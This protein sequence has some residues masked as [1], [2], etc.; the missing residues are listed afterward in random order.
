M[1]TYI[2]VITNEILSPIVDSQV[3]RPLASKAKKDR[4]VVVALVPVGLFLRPSLKAKM[5]ETA[6]RRKKLY[7]IETRYVLSG[8][9][10]LKLP[11]L[12]KFLLS[13][14]L[15]ALVGEASKAILL[16]R[17]A[18]A[19]CSVMLASRKLED[20]CKLIFDC[21]GDG[22]SELVGGLGAGWDFNLWEAPIVEVYEQALKEE[23]R[24]CG[25]D[26][27]I[28]VSHK[29]A[30]M[31]NE[32]HGVPFSKMRIEPCKVDLQHFSNI[33]RTW[34]REQLNV[35]DRKV[36]C[37]LGSLAWYQLPDQSIRVYKAFK[38]HHP[39]AVFLAITTD[40]NKMK[41]MLADAGFSE[42]DCMAIQVSSEDVPR[43][44]SAADVGLLLREAN[45]VN[46]VASPVKFAE[47]LACGVP[48][49]L[50]ESIGDYSELVLT[51]GLGGVVDISR[52][53][54]H[55]DAGIDALIRQ[56]CDNKNLRMRCRLYVEENLSWS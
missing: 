22:P 3:F 56:L 19:M 15:C 17:N 48:V 5:Q 55:L 12:E 9:S 2:Q 18:T 10:R 20:R 30:E 26:Q 54:A 4:V 50:T 36:V 16:A 42:A 53:D 37:Y 33:N 45:P 14:L 51:E 28:C 7:G 13:R 27:I 23:K 34:A 44:L 43:Y 29:M 21:R 40:V 11:L 35:G 8:T 38:K 52:T 6:Q 39:E 49:L 1:E 31:L 41:S 24:A 46:A 25:A 47:Y 32:R